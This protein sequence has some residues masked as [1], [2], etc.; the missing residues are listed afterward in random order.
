MYKKDMQ[1]RFTRVRFWSLTTK[2]FGMGNK[3]NIRYTVHVMPASIEQFYQEAGRAGRKQN[4]PDNYALHCDLADKW[5]QAKEILK[6][7]DLLSIGR[8]AARTGR[9][10]GQWFLLNS[11]KGR[12]EE[13]ENTL[14]LWRDFM[15]DEW[16]AGVRTVQIP[17]GQDRESREKS[18]YRLAGHCRGLHGAV[19]GRGL[20]QKG[21]FSVELSD[22]GADNVRGSLSNYLRRL[23]FR[24]M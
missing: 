6:E 7:E 11:Y 23:N 24:I 4:C 17:F 10:V 8:S 14:E 20:K 18:I 16:E 12:E 2:S 21:W 9:C 1:R 15:A 3:E 5:E 13:K 22:G 19:D